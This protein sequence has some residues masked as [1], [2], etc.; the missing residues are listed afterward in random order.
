MIETYG[1][2]LIE[3]FIEGKEFT[4]LCAENVNDPKKPFT[5]VPIEIIFP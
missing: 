4:C 5:Y 1:G 2:C 3:E